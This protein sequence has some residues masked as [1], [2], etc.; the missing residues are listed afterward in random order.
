MGRYIKRTVVGLILMLAAGG[1]SALAETI[2][3]SP[4]EVDVAPNGLCSLIEAIENAEAD[5]AVHADCP[6][7]SGPDLIQLPGG[8]DYVLTTPRVAGTGGAPATGLPEITTVLVIRGNQTVIRRSNAPGTPPFRLLAALGADLTLDGI[9][10][11]GGRVGPHPLLGGAAVYQRGGRLLGERV[12]F[13]DNAI[14]GPGRGGALQVGGSSTLPRTQTTLRDCRFAANAV[15]ADTANSN[16]GGGAISVD[17]ATMTIERCAFVDNRAGPL[18]TGPTSAGG[19]GGA[20]H[21]T[22]VVPAPGIDDTEVFI[23]HTTI[24]GNVARQGGAIAAV[25]E[26]TGLSLLVGLDYVTVTGNRAVGGTGAGLWGTGLGTVAFAYGSSVIHGNG[27][28]VAS[29]DCL[30]ASAG[31][32]F[33]SL[34]RNLLDPDDLCPFDPELDILDANLGT[35]L[36][37]N[38]IDDAH[39]PRVGGAL[40]N[41]S[42]L[43]CTPGVSRDQKRRLRANGPG[44][45]G[46]SCEI[47][48]IELYGD[49]G[50][51]RIFAHGFESVPN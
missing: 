46:N 11:R 3:V 4:G 31:V 47:G 6:A 21:V 18:A 23:S 49:D 26:T 48:A 44:L 1:G 13:E 16:L 32:W 14:T 39:A 9:T 12:G 7:G 10:F 28:T 45:G 41:A 20:I 40:I 36:D 38:R 15:Q 30:A 37:P 51:D 5:A 29:R 2:L 33:Q 19:V 17:G 27:T 42:G 22:G 34:W 24:S 35:H 25:V 50:S 43:G 8:T